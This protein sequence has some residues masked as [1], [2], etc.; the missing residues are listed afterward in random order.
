MN[1]VGVVIVTYNSDRVIDKTLRALASQSRQPDK[2]IIVDNSSQDSKYLY[3]FTYS[4]LKVELQTRNTGFCEGNNIGASSLKGYDFIFFLNHDA[5]I[6]QHFIKDAVDFMSDPRNADVGV[7]TGQMLGYN[8]ETERPTGLIDSTGIFQSFYGRWYDRAQGSLAAKAAAKTQE[9]P[10][11]CGALMF[12]RRRAL[13]EVALGKDEIFDERFFMYKEDI[14]LSLRL[15]RSGWRL[16][17]VPELLAYHCRGWNVDRSKMSFEA[18]Y[19]SAINEL[20][21][22]KRHPSLA[23]LFTLLKLA[24]VTRLGLRNYAH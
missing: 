21:L 13:D 18:K 8:L 7:I 9:V 5:F 19:L 11:V 24:F 14:E 17:Y 22:Y 16:L 23:V 1:S 20:R 12:C 4:W 10:A 15:R 2:V 3:D 6:F